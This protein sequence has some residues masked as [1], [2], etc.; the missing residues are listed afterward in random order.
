MLRLRNIRF[1]ALGYLQIFE[2]KWKE[3]LLIFGIYQVALLY[4]IPDGNKLEI[5]NSGECHGFF[6]RKGAKAQSFEG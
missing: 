1:Q 4:R 2:S 5:V 6:Y 3:F